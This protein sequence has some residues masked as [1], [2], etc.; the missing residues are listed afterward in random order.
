[1]GAGSPRATSHTSRALRSSI[2]GAVWGMVRRAASRL[3]VWARQCEMPQ[4]RIESRLVS[5]SND[6]PVHRERA[7][8]AAHTIARSTILAMLQFARY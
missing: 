6:W 3:R 8:L 5:T 4:S 1:M 2:T 7:G